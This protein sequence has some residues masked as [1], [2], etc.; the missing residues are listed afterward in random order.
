[1]LASGVTCYSQK[2]SQPT[3]STNDSP[4]KSIIEILCDCAH[5]VFRELGPHYSEVTYQNALEVECQL[6][7]IRFV[8]QPTLNILYKGQIV[9]FQRPD[10][11][12]ENEV[13]VEMKA[14]REINIG[15]RH[16][17]NWKLQL[18]NYLKNTHYSGLLVVFGSTCVECL[19]VW[20]CEQHQD[21][22][23]RKFP[24]TTTVP[25][26]ATALS[27]PPTTTAPITMAA[28]SE[29][30]T[31]TVPIT[32]TALSESLT[33]DMSHEIVKA[34]TQPNAASQSVDYTIHISRSQ[35]SSLFE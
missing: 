29:S 3:S 34:P 33:T 16:L 32:T 21:S 11:I 23:K 24:P 17:Q 19:P 26:T 22:K 18:K 31:T 2:F 14:S 9:G 7:Q 15:T 25:N 20:N 8:R 10:M 12:I 28:P 4:T 13:V 30:L 1:M 35:P 5:Q 27:E 6:R